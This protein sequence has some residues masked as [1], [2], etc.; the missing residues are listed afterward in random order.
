MVPASDPKL[1]V[2]VVV[3]DPQGDDLRRLGGGAG[4]P[5]DRRL[6][7]AALRHQPV[8]ARPC[9]PS[10]MDPADTE[11]ALA[12]L[13]RS[14]PVAPMYLDE[15]FPGAPAVDI[16][17]L[18]YDNRAVGPRDLFFCV[19]GFT[20]DGHEFAADAVA[21]GRRGA[22]RRPPARPRHSAGR[23]STTYAG[24]W[25]PRPRRSTAIPTADARA[26]RRHRDQRQDHHGLPGPGAARGRRAPDRPA[27]H[28]QERDRRRRV[29]RSQR[30]TPEAI[31]L[32]RIVPGDA[33][34]RRHAPA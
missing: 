4:V 19:R 13:G 3:D 11:H 32:Q 6:G 27:G 18:A 17:G 30:T 14:Y 10:A 2:A 8:P 7:G 15:L 28:R 34:R 1:V 23:W 12:R 29:A 31:D 5:E 22:G 9:P 21:R 16:A 26:R 33:R 24:R 25:R 20:R